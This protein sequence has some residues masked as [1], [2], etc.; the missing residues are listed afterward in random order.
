MSQ[1]I[2]VYLYLVG[3]SLIDSAIDWTGSDLIGVCMPVCDSTQ[4][5]Y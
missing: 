2:N 1:V 4:Q 5:V 3:D